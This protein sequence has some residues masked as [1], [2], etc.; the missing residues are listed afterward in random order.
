MYVCKHAC[1]HT[2]LIH[3]SPSA[4]TVCVSY[5]SSKPRYAS[6]CSFKPHACW[7]PVH[8][9]S[10]LWACTP[11]SQQKAAKKY[12]ILMVPVVLRRP[13]ARRVS[14]WPRLKC[15]PPPSQRKTARRERTLFPVMLLPR[16]MHAWSGDKPSSDRLCTCIS[17]LIYLVHWDIT[18]EISSVRH[19]LSWK[20]LIMFLMQI[21]TVVW[22]CSVSAWIH[23]RSGT[24]RGI[25]WHNAGV[26]LCNIYFF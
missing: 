11:P 25:I 17:L 13:H 24:S 3:I 15:T 10:S 9:A 12:R 2:Q 22:S 5:A 20:F 18:S 7:S 1:M 8:V 21:S 4:W 14:A 23:S 16:L 26:N 19:F 6:T